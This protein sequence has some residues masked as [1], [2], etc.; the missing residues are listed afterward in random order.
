MNR[1][2]A[3]GML[4]QGNTGSEIL[5]ILDVIQQDT[6]NSV[7]LVENETSITLEFWYLLCAPYE[8]F[9]WGTYVGHM[10]SMCNA[11]V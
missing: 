1:T 3:L 7:N 8:L 6:D 5:E 2:L 9:M 11:Y 10:D 4:A